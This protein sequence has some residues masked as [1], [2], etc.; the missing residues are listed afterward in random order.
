MKMSI[1]NLPTFDPESGDAL[2]VIETPKG[3]PE[4]LLFIVE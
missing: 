3:K 1:G 2:A 4:Q